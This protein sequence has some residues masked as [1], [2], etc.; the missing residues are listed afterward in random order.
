MQNMQI[1]RYDEKEI[2]CKREKCTQ[3]YLNIHLGKLHLLEMHQEMDN[4]L[5]WTWMTQRKD[6]G[7]EKVWQP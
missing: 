5:A 4:H 1:K 7:S 3:I 2:H 6:R